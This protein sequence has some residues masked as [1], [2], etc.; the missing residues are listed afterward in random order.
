MILDGLQNAGIEVIILAHS[1]VRL[2]SNPSGADFH[3]YELT[4]N[5]GG[6]KPGPGPILKAWCDCLLFA[7]F[8]DSTKLEK[9]DAKAEDAVLKKGKGVTG[10]RVL[11]TTHAAAWDA[12]NRLSLPSEIPLSYAEFAKLAGQKVEQK[13]TASAA[14]PAPIKAAPAE[15]TNGTGE[16]KATPS[17]VPPTIDGGEKKDLK[18]PAQPPKG[19]SPPPSLDLKAM[20]AV[21]TEYMKATGCQP[22][23]VIEKVI[24]PLGAKS[25]RAMLTTDYVKVIEQLRKIYPEN[26]AHPVL[27]GFIG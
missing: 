25:L 18:A 17:P 9:R 1:I 20:N 21:L 16:T 22:P 24:K 4:L 27:D 5:K 13:P 19:S 7:C 10:E 15:P 2:F 11:K 3:R 6:N 14:P 26:A 12:K 8:S 23:D